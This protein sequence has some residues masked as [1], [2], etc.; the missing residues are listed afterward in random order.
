MKLIATGL[1]A[2]FLIGASI[3][4][5]YH[6]VKIIKRE[7]AIHEA[8]SARNEAVENT[9]NEY[10]KLYK[11]AVD[12]PDTIVTERVFVKAKCPVPTA[13]GSRVDDGVDATRVEL[14]QR[15]VRN[16]TKLADH[17]SKQY[18]KCAAMLHS[19]QQAIKA[20]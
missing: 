15:V 16:L 1:I 14:D 17:H 19:F 8:E 7:I 6:Q 10:Y 13:E 9:I 12:R 2:G 4:N 18:E 11:N 5:E 20:Q 3:V